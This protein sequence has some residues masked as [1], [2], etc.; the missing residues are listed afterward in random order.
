VSSTRTGNKSRHM[1]TGLSSIL[2]FHFWS[3]QN[4]VGMAKMEAGVWSL[5]RLGK[6]EVGKVWAQSR[7]GLKAPDMPGLR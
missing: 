2:N 5:D 3:Q 4:K 6:Y 1:E 7:M